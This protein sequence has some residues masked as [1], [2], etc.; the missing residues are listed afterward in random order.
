MSIVLAIPDQ[1]Y[2]FHHKDSVDFLSAIYE[3]EDCDTVVHLGDLIDGHAVSRFESD[4]DGFS[5]GHEFEK[6]VDELGELYALFPNV[7][8]CYG[9]HDIRIASKAYSAG[10]PKAFVKDFSDI[11]QSP[12]GWDWQDD[13]VIDGVLYFHGTGFTGVFATRQMLLAKMQSVVH[14]HTHGHAGVIHIAQSTYPPKHVMGMNAGSL[15][16]EKAYAMAY[17]KHSRVKCSTGAGVIKN[18]NMF[19]HAMS[20][21]K[22][23]RWDGRL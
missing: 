5:A 15:V 4:P 21:N 17:A 12:E 11:I 14:G 18:G 19:W 13:H 16:D 20:L 7:K 8:A 1:H 2:P 6:A 22:S 23:G 3:T 9:N 10:I